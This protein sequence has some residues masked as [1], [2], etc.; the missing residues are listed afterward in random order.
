YV[1]TEFLPGDDFR[2]IQG[3]LYEMKCEGY[4]PILA[5]AERSECLY[6]NID[7]IEELANMG[8]KIQINAGSIAGHQGLGMKWYCKKLMKRNLLHLVGTDAHDM[9]KRPPRMDACQKVMTKTMGEDY[10]RRILILNPQKIIT[11][12]VM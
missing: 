12:E 3:A 5:H 6:K 8:I 9:E 10:T 1:L 4:L 11:N 2:K 7:Y